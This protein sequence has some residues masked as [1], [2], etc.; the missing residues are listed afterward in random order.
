MNGMSGE[1]LTGEPYNASL[2]RDGQA[3]VGLK[4]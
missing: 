1:T 2:S 4:R 3:G